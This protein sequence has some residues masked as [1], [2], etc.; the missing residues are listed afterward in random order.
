VNPKDHLESAV[1]IE[2]ENDSESAPESEVPNLLSDEAPLKVLI[3]D[4]PGAY[5]G[6]GSLPAWQNNYLPR[7]AQAIK[8]AGSQAKARS[9]VEFLVIYGDFAFP[10]SVEWYSAF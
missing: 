1:T 8:G 7:L 5:G 9:K 4:P 3:I 6:Y 2:A 10:A